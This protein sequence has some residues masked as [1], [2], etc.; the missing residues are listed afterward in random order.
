MPRYVAFLR[1]INLGR[2]RPA[3]SE[4]REHFEELGFANVSTFIVSGNVIFE[5]RAVQIPKLEQRIEKHLAAKLGYEVDTFIC[6]EDEVIAATEL[7]AFPDGTPKG[8]G[9]YVTFY[10]EPIDTIM[11]KALTDC[12]SEVDEFH[13]NGRELYR[14]CRIKSSDSKIW[15]HRKSK[16]SSSLPARCVT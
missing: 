3:M 14:L 2:R 9:I 8:G 1:G 4:L 16:P 13:V 7:E 6:R 11:M 5:T 10:K 15:P 12:R